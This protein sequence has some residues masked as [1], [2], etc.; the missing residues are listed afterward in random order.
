L[1]VE[2]GTIDRFL[3]SCAEIYGEQRQFASFRR[4]IPFLGTHFDKTIVH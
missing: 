2:F 3:S 4:R 1:T